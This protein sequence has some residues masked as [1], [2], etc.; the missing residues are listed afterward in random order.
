M[1][2]NGYGYPNY[3]F[4]T[5]RPEMHN[6]PPVAPQTPS[7]GFSAQQG[8]TP[9][10][11]FVCRPVAAKIE[12]E[13]AQIPFDGSTTY[14]VDTGSGKIYAKTFDFNTGTAP[15]VTYVREQ[16]EADKPR[17]AT[18]DELQAF[19]DE[20]NALRAELAAPSA[21]PSRKAVKHYD[22]DDE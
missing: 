22:P 2:Y 14:F 8:V 20:L 16:P 19:R 1:A 15:L 17:Y 7:A 5:F 10:P 21:P 18:V 4:Q 12:A 3:G 6:Y 11:G 13:T 9:A